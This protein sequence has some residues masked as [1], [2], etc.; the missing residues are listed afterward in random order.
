MTNSHTFYNVSAPAG[1]G[2]TYAAI[3]HAIQLAQNNQKVVIAQPSIQLIDQTEADILARNSGVQV[4]KIVSPSGSYNSQPVTARILDHMKDA[5]PAK[6]EVLLI[7]QQVLGRLPNTYRQFWHIIVDEV[8]GAFKAHEMNIAKSHSF[9]TAHLELGSALIEQFVEVQ[10]SDVGGLRTLAEN[11]SRDTAFAI[12]KNLVDDVLNADKLLV[13]NADEYAELVS[14]N[15]KRKTISFYAFQMPEFVQGF[16]SVT[17]M[18]ANFADTE[19][20]KIWEKLFNI[21]WKPHPTIGSSLRYQQH[22]NGGRLTIKYL[23][24]G[25]WSQYHS[26]LPHGNGTILDAVVAAIEAEL[27]E[28]YI[29]QANDKHGAFLFDEGI[30]LPQVTVGINRKSYQSKHKVAL[31]KAI[32]HSSGTAK[33]LQAIGLTDDE[34]KVT[35]Q[36]QNEYQA[37]MRSSLR[38]PTATDEVTVIVVSER[39]ARW[40]E[41]KFPNSTVEKMQTDIPEPRSK[42]QPAERPRCPAE[43]MHD[44]RQLAKVKEAATRGE[45]Y[46]AKPWPGP[47]KGKGLSGLFK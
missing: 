25:N 22:I 26:T 16:A 29:W 5:D 12:F 4:T 46:V 6:G 41:Q 38:V 18:G 40:L 14:N 9:M 42:G 17:I 28:D 30:M 8:P 7:S 20:F 44:S 10:A 39:S 27:I 19:L 45:V 15:G 35:L 23:I 47:K 21:E 2:K 3:S 31:V 43:R 11:K 33:F 34:L 24:D 37:M 13:V 36:Y 1:S 32:N